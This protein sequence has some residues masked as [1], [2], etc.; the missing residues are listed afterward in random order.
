M[1]R[2]TNIIILATAV[3]LSAAACSSADASSSESATDTTVTT[4]LPQIVTVPT[5]R[6]RT[7]S[8]TETETSQ[9]SDLSTEASTTASP[10]GSPTT[11]PTP[12]AV[13]AEIA[14]SPE[15]AEFAST[16]RVL[17]DEWSTHLNAFGEEALDHLDDVSNAPSAMSLLDES[18]AMIAAIGPDVDDPTLITIR[19]FADGLAN[20]ITFAV[21]DDQNAA[22]SVF[23]QLQG[24]AESLTTALDQLQA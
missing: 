1:S 20:A 23:L 18:E 11:A 9:A 19:T 4:A 13:T 6:T 17:V 21:D 16:N 5:E 7:S 8:D 24:D 3:S 14:P 10:V 2:R 22:M 15:V 12:V